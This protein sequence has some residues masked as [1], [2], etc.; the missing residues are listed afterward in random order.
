MNRHRDT[1]L[2]MASDSASRATTNGL[3]ALGN[4]SFKW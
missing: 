2:T 1:R 3:Q 4:G